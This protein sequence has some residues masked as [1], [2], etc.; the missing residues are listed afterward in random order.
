[1]VTNDVVMMRIKNAIKE[2]CEE[3][4]RSPD[5]PLQVIFNEA[6]K[7]WNTGLCM[8]HNFNVYEK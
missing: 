2:A 7:N 5:D 4:N 6:F 1:M 8:D 3:I